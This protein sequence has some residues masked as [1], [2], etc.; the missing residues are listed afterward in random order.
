[1]P[2]KQ[3][4]PELIG[5]RYELIRR[6]DSGGMGEVYHAYDRLDG[7]NVALK[8]LLTDVE[9]HGTGVTTIG[10]T[11][12]ERMSIAREF[13]TL[14]SLRHPSI[15]NVLDYGF[16]DSQ[17]PYFTMTLLQEAEAMDVAARDLPLGQQVD[18][19]IQ[20]L[21]ALAYLHRR[22]IVHRDL[23]PSNVLVIWEHNHPQVRVMDFGL[24]IGH[25]AIGEIAGTISYMA[26]E[27][28][29]EQAATPAADLYAMGVM[30]YEVL[31]GGHPFPAKDVTELLMDIIQKMPDVQG[32][33]PPLRPVVERLLVKDP[34]DRYQDAYDVI[35]D[36]S[37]VLDI[38]LPVE[39]I[40]IRES[41]LQ[42]AAFVGREDEMA[43]LTTA[44]SHTVDERLGSAWLI[45][46]ESGVG[47]TRLLE[48]LRTYAL[49]IHR[50]GGSGALL[51]RGQ[52]I[53]GGGKPYQM[54]RPVMK[55]LALVTDLTD[56]EAAVL[57]E[58]VPDIERLLGREVP[59]APALDAETQQQ[60]L[61][62]TIIDVFRRQ[63]RPMLLLLED[64]H[65]LSESLESLNQ[66][67]RVVEEIP[68]LIV[69]T[70]RDDERPYL[71]DELPSMNIVPL[72]RLSKAEI[73]ELTTSMLGP[74]GRNPDVLDLI[75][76]ETEG[77][78][79]F[80][81]EVVRAL[82]EESGGLGDIG[83][84][85][86]PDRVFA[87]GIRMI[88]QR[89]L[90]RVP[91]D[92][93]RLVDLASVVGR[94]IDLDVMRHVAP[95]ADLDAWLTTCANVAVVNFVDG[96]WQ[97]AHDKL[98]E[99]V[100][101]QID[102]D[103]RPGLHQRVAEA[104]QA[105]H[106]DD[107]ETYY[108]RLALHY[109]ETPDRDSERH[110]CSLGGEQ[111]VRRFANEEALSLLSRALELTE[112]SN[113]REIFRLLMLRESVFDTLGLR[114]EQQGDLETITKL[115][116]EM[117]E[118]RFLN[119]VALRRADFDI[120]R[121]DYSSALRTMED[122]TA[123]A[124][125]CEDQVLEIEG[126][127]RMGQ[128]MMRQ[129]NFIDARP[130]LERA[131]RLAR[132]SE[133]T[134]LEANLLRTLGSVTLDQ[135]D[136]IG[137]RAYYQHSADMAAAMGDRLSQAKAVNNLGEVTRYQGLF[138]ESRTFYSRAFDL[139]GT[140]G[141]PRGEGLT[142]SNMALV[143]RDLGD[144]TNARQQY[145][146]ALGLSHQTGDRYSESWCLLGLGLIHDN[147]GQFDLANGYLDGALLLCR[148]TGQRDGE[149]WTLNGLALLSRH[150][151]DF[152]KTL[153]YSQRSLQIARSVGAK[154]IEARALTNLGYA[155]A[156]KP[157][158]LT[159]GAHAF[160][161]ALKLHD[162][163]GETHLMSEARAGLAHIALSQDE[164]RV[165]RNHAA[166]AM[167]YL[168]TH[169]AY[170]VEDPIQVYW[171]CLQAFNAAGERDRA[172]DVLAAAHALIEERSRNL[173]VDSMQQSYREN[174]PAH[175]AILH[176]YR[177][178]SGSGRVR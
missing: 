117:D 77:N 151:Q 98:R 129:G 88:V 41:F 172:N 55:H 105:V 56:L 32:V 26:P 121:G 27:V 127:Y 122:L 120:V 124:L 25:D 125:A 165:A 61:Q 93:Q 166:A 89:R 92:D 40:A 7:Q 39:S 70:Y 138:E 108:T 157:Q 16:D 84:M 136:Y 85:T 74:S 104:I 46:G 128:A 87:R 160:R 142:L 72:E 52:G 43:Q 51:L 37:R 67:A 176:L 33:P 60:R 173:L 12:D 14:A 112:T 20:T 109:S 13:R 145:N 68:L 64:L 50:E 2:S 18:L 24:A 168:D 135:G 114:V 159:V 9:A 106:P 115:A 164:F 137:A 34:N 65:W 62:A 57:K 49:V 4:S 140:I 76:R 97:F 158:T 19:I 15:I 54:W 169:P 119:Q 139:F 170:G 48:E 102:D 126:L 30:A 21:Q 163:L 130:T 152:G 23:K 134:V 103:R 8:R 78:A 147:I 154:P 161:Q 53:Y 167:D 81:V 178:R 90:E 123:A 144:Y 82:A 149:G 1:M 11:Q 118:P 66:L 10:N 110:F 83:K 96:Q 101:A 58:I 38:P 148:Q 79:F 44:L 42:A 100:L 95:K 29:R 146:T 71:P 153:I 155:L 63:K 28:L 175:R 47:K 132:E 45:A 107:L 113:T 86:L 171:V 99:T 22:D 156:E 59:D 35:S 116:Q 6:L 94:R 141:N 131:L 174:L 3:P 150:R 73:A 133:S 5:S 91:P 80:L 17:R 162:E 36:I 75:Q 111:A 177:Q 143:L 31:T 69:A